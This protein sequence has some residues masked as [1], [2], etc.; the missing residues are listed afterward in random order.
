MLASASGA[1]AATFYGKLKFGKPDPTWMCNGMLAG[2]VAITAPCAFVQPWAA[3]TIGLIA[4]TLVV[5]A[6]RFIERRGVDDPVGAVAVHGV[7][8][9]FGVL[10]V[11]LFADGQYGAGWNGTTTTTKGVTG[12]FYDASEGLGQ[13]GSQ[14]IAVVVLWTVIF[15]IAFAFFKIQNALMK[16]GI[17]PTA[18]VES[19]GMDM[20][21][22][23]AYAYVD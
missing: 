12:L 5:I 18:E 21:E 3:M 16:G 23:G 2:L 10:A 17:R 20:P 14:A 7:N 4:G 22:M 6:A 19:E 9:T 15:G 11:G 13:L 8:G 1:L